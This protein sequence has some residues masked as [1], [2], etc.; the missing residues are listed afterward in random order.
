MDPADLEHRQVLLVLD[1]GQNFRV[2]EG[3]WH[4]LDNLLYIPPSVP[5]NF[6][7]FRH[8][9][10]LATEICGSKQCGSVCNPGGPPRCT[11]TYEDDG[12]GTSAVNG[13]TIVFS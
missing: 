10:L 11:R 7:R 13:P 5:D 2:L 8:F 1:P 4:S 9:N 12:E 3:V 6:T